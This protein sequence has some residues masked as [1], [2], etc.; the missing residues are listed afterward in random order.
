[1]EVPHYGCVALSAEKGKELVAGAL[2][3][4]QVAAEKGLFVVQPPAK[5]WQ[6]FA[7]HLHRSVFLAH[8]PKT[9]S[10]WR[11]VGTKIRGVCR[12]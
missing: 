4:V 6:N 2:Q 9:Y 7:E 8:R 11:G 5:Q 1:M 3:E 10:G 12:E